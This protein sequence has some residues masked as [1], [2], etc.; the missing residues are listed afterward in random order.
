[1]TL[2]VF[3]CDKKIKVS[4]LIFENQIFFFLEKNRKI[5]FIKIIFYKSLKIEN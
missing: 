1:M 4:I 3:Y 5:K 2:K